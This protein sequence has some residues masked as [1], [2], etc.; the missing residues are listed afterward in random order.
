M[1]FRQFFNSPSDSYTCLLARGEALIIDP[2]L[3]QVAAICS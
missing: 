1:I 2:V 3:E